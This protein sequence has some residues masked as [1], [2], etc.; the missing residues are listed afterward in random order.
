MKKI[1]FATLLTGMITLTGLSASAAH[2]ERDIDRN[3]SGITPP[4]VR[5][6]T[7]DEQHRDIAARDMSTAG[8]LAASA[9]AAGIY[10]LRRRAKSR[11]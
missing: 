2:R 11:A 4:V 8:L 7:G 10:A 9:M 3:T 6:S 1:L 5:A